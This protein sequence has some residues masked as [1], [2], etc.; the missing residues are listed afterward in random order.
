M[1][2][3]AGDLDAVIPEVDVI[4]FVPIDVRNELQFRFP[5]LNKVYWII[6]EPSRRA[7]SWLLNHDWR[8][9]RNR[10]NYL[11]E[12]D[13]TH[14]KVAIRPFSDKLCHHE[15]IEQESFDFVE[16]VD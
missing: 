10:R 3:E 13:R 15:C 1:S 9:M 14:E 2:I 4:H 8:S 11:K 12:R 6:P 5:R 7:R 16:L